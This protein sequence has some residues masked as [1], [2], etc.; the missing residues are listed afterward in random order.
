MTPQRYPRLTYREVA[1]LKA[2]AMRGGGHRPILIERSRR[3]AA[4]SLWRRNL[5]E[6]WYRQS[7]VARGLQGPFYALTLNGCR[8]VSTLTL[9]SN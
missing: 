7:L 2:V 8:V 1:L 6:V 4:P 3:R 9:T 5:L